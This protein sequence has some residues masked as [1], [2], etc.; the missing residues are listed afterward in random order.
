MLG[1]GIETLR[2]QV[3]RRFGGALLSDVFGIEALEVLE[4]L[5]LDRRP[6]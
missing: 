3:V 2:P 6:Y 1:F 5:L 4:G